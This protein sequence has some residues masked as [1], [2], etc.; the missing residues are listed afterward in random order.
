MKKFLLGSLILLAAAPWQTAFAQ[1][2]TLP[3]EISGHMKKGKKLDQV[4]LNPKYDT[5]TGFVIGMVNTQAEGTY[6]NTI[7]YLPYVLGRLTIPGSTNQLNLVVTSLDDKSG[8]SSNLSIADLN[9]EGQV[10]DRDG[11]LLMAFRDSEH[12]ESKE[13]AIH[14]LEACMDHLASKLG[15]EL[16][17]PFEDALVLKMGMA[18][19][20]NTNPSGLVPGA[21]KGQPQTLSVGE[22]LMQLD[23]LKKSGLITEEEYNQKKAELLK[24]L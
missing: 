3:P 23:N 13:T 22:R 18:K 7:D 2:Q 5:S 24:E 6:A 10:V 15:K 11:Q 16:G 1:V 4:W 14:G 12:D 9:V 19:G 21:P 20:G 8:Y 17:K